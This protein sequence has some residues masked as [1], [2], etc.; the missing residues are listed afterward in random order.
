MGAMT[1][2]ICSGVQPP[3][4]AAMEIEGNAATPRPIPVTVAK[5]LPSGSMHAWRRRISLRHSARCWHRIPVGSGQADEADTPR[6]LTREDS[7]LGR[8]MYRSDIGAISGH[9]HDD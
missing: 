7:A 3:V 4:A 1:A 9:G 6:V 2:M 8:G 5:P